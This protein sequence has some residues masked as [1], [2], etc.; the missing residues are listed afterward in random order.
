MYV[1]D[2]GNCPHCDRYCGDYLTKHINACWKN[3]NNKVSGICGYCGKEFNRVLYGKY[4]KGKYCSKECGLKYSRSK[5]RKNIIC[6]QCGCE[7]QVPILRTN[8]CD[9]CFNLSKKHKTCFFCGK[10]AS[11]QL[12]NGK[13][14]CCKYVSQ[15]DAIKNKNSLGLKRAYKLG[16][17]KADV[18][19]F[20]NLGIA[21]WSKNKCTFTDNRIKS[22]YNT[23][24]DIF[25]LNSKAVTSVVRN[26][27]LVLNLLEYKCSFC[28]NNGVW[29]NKKLTLEL[30]HIDGDKT[31]NLL[32]N[33]RFLCPN[34]H[35][36]TK[37]YKGK[38]INNKQMIVP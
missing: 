16:I 22:K 7:I 3:P 20:L 17:M 1:P 19:K 38:N 4:D 35:S 5:N 36:Q 34:C 31:N 8:L 37:T 21:D 29:F 9:D 25:C 27:I 13:W 26:Y 14:C 18:N 10:E 32:E 28:N 6:E 23:I 11:Y 33:L 24:Y 2:S 30:D 12:K 15:C